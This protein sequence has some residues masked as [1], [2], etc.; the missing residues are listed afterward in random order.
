MA[1]CVLFQLCSSSTTFLDSK[2][3]NFYVKTSKS[4]DYKLQGN[5]DDHRFGFEVKEHNQFHHTKTGS[6]ISRFAINQTFENFISSGIA[7]DG[8]RIGCF[9][10]EVDGKSYMTHYVADAKGYRLVPYDKI[11]TVYPKDDGKPRWDFQLKLFMIVFRYFKN[12]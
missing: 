11:I 9:S 1:F 2:K 4:L 10:H 7:E 6:I 8:V 5:S 12:S 3:Q